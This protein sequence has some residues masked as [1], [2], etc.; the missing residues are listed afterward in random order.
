MGRA[1]AYRILGTGEGGKVRECIISLGAWVR[2]YLCYIINKVHFK[3]ISSIQIAP[4][5]CLFVFIHVYTF[6]H[7]LDLN[8]LSTYYV[9]ICVPEGFWAFVMN[10]V[11]FI[12]WLIV[13]DEC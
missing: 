3:T 11:Q 13:R 10:T 6:S 4:M 8:S 7:S 9:P 5:A 2:L 12:G 1:E